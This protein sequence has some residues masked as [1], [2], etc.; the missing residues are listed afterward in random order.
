MKYQILYFVSKLFK[1]II[2]IWLVASLTDDLLPK[3]LLSNKDLG[4]P[5]DESFEE[6]FEH[7]ADMKGI[8]LCLVQSFL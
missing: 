6:L 4:D 3:E 2:I 1:T 5:G 8:M 7:F